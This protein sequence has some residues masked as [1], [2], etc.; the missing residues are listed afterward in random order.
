M[1]RCVIG[2][3]IGG[4]H[5]KAAALNSNGLITHV[6]Q[7]PCPLWKGI[8]SLNLAVKQILTSIP[9]K[10]CQHVMTMTGELVDLF[11]SRD[12]GV[13]T[14]IDTLQQLLPGKDLLV[15]AGLEG[16]LKVD[17]I[18]KHHF[19]SI[20]SANWLASASWA[21]S[22]QNNGLFIDI[23]STTTDI[24]VLSEQKVV[25]VGLTDYERLV[26]GELVYTGCIRTAV[27][28]VTQSAYFQGHEMGLMA[29]YFATM[30]D[31]YRLTGELNEAHDQTDT[32]DGAEKTIS[33]SALRLSRMTGYEYTEDDLGLWRQFAKDIKYQQ[34]NNIEKACQ[35]QLSRN[36]ISS[37]D[38]FIGAGVGRF[39]VRKIADNLGYSYLDFDDM[40]N[41]TLDD[42]D[43]NVADCAPAVAVAVAVAVALL[44]NSL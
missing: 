3:D 38:S 31:V 6:I 39:L 11:D 2:W 17:N 42:S 19:I 21:A 34:R 4:A 40:V 43:L 9:S 41:T 33:A 8:D 12:Q 18:Q 23:G 20:A 36:L 37:H 25:A 15:Y 16:F 1:Q 5:V 35:R 7:Q 30:A 29:E 32:A 28:A 27:M 24:L 44:A 14:I 13:Q 10:N 26:S 22:I